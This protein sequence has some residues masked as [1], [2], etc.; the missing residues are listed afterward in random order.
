VLVRS[1]RGTTPLADRSAHAPR[2]DRLFFGCDGP[3]PFGSTSARRI[4]IFADN[5]RDF[6]SEGSPVIAGSKPLH[7]F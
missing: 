6:S 7:Q 5:E 2:A 4:R 1:C 3:D